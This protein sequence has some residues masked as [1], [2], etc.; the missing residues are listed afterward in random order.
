MKQA[1]TSAALRGLP[2]KGN[3]GNLMQHWTL[4]EVL[5]T[6]QRHAS[7]LSYVA[8]LRGRPRDG[9]YGESAD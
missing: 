4:C 6:A 2:Y 3:V 5:A 7:C 1:D 8:E 9:P